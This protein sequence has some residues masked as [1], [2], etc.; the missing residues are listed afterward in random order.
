MAAAEEVVAERPATPPLGRHLAAFVALKEEGKDNDVVV[1]GRARRRAQRACAS[2]AA[3]AAAAPGAAVTATT[4]LL[5][6]RTSSSMMIM[7]FVRLCTMR[8]RCAGLLLL[9]ALLPFMPL[10]QNP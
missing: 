8:T 6:R 10:L 5:A 3:Y 9:L 1:P 2:A 7:S 4:P